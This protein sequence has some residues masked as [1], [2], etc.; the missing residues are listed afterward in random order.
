MITRIGSRSRTTAS[1]TKATTAAASSQHVVASFVRLLSILAT[2]NSGSSS[3][4]CT[5]HLLHSRSLP[6]QSRPQQQP[7]QP[8]RHTSSSSSHITQQIAVYSRRHQQGVTLRDLMHRGLNA[9]TNPSALLQS[10]QFMYRELPIRLAKR[11]QE[12]ECLPYGLSQEE[13]I[14]TVRGW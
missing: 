14:K 7:H 9:H 13:P 5:K 8:H 3:S 6:C 11:V 4:S 1:S 10:A 2:S 12:L